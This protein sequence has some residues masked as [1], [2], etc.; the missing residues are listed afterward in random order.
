MKFREIFYLL[1]VVSVFATGIFSQVTFQPRDADEEH[2]WRLY[3]QY[4]D[5]KKKEAELNKKIAQLRS[6]IQNASHSSIGGLGADPSDVAAKN[7][8][9]EDLQTE[10]TKQEKLLAAWQK[11]FY[12]RYGDLKDSDKMTY[13]ATTKQNMDKIKFA[14]IYFPFDPK[15]NV[16]AA[17]STQSA[18]STSLTLE[19]PGYWG[20]LSYTITGA[21][22]NPPSGGDSGKVAG[23]QYTGE[24]AANTLTVSGTA[25]SDNPSSGPGSLDYYELKVS[26]TVGKETKNYSYIAPKG[27]KLN[28]SF[29]FSVPV[30]KGEAGSFGI[31]L[32]EQN[33]NYGPHGWVVGGNLAAA[34]AEAMTTTKPPAPAKT[35]AADAE[36]LLKLGKEQRDKGNYSEALAT[37]NRTL[38]IDSLNVEAFRLRGMT[39]RDL[40]DFAGAMRDYN[41][42]LEIEPLDPYL[43]SSRAVLK[44]RLS[45]FKGSLADF[46]LAIQFNPEVSFFYFAR[47]NLRNDDL[48]DYAGAISDYDKCIELTAPE[49]RAKP[50][51]KRAE[52]KIAI[53]DKS[54]AI[55]DFEKSLA[56][57]PDNESA[58]NNLARLKG[59]TSSVT[60]PSDLISIGVVNSKALNLAKPTYPP[61]AKGTG[62]EGTVYVEVIIDEDGNVISAKA[63]SGHNLLRNPAEDAARVSK[64]SPTLLS[65]RKIKVKGVIVYNF[66]A[67]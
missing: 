23:R 57:N 32:L 61:A 17:P 49:W 41:L 36:K 12:W 43:Y 52:A 18:P 34:K 51:S 29:S 47:G 62:A 66:T 2:G 22:L 54:G 19:I 28:K 56:L 31:S 33:A 42:A 67:Q 46:D 39:K 21:R 3:N 25:V 10:Q 40:N 59:K 38:E 44:Q 13:D 26:V 15:N 16:D 65:G 63:V 30:E 58:K 7:K 50:L 35:N 37:L 4:K 1:I 9:L 48:K 6:D 27:E 55:A 11:K 60:E 14:L 53:N 24:L 45:D 20:H 8:A 64:F 5:S